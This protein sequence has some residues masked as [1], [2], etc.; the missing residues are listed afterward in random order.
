MQAFQHSAPTY[1]PGLIFCESILGHNASGC[2]QFTSQGL[3]PVLL[4]H[5][6]SLPLTIYLSGLHHWPSASYIF[7]NHSYTI[8]FFKYQTAL[9][10]FLPSGYI[11]H[12]LAHQWSDSAKSQ[13]GWYASCKATLVYSIPWQNCTI[14]PDFFSAHYS[15]IRPWSKF[16]QNIK[17]R[18]SQI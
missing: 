11:T 17:E 15:N 5:S 18:E 4:S 3:S 6:Q 9:Y 13:F 2:L 10:L 16:S 1:L 7:R 14:I 12:F 8:N